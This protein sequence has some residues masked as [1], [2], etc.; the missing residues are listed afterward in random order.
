MGRA[1]IITPENSFDNISDDVETINQKKG[2]IDNRALC[3]LVAFLYSVFEL[4]KLD[5]T[6]AI[7]QS[8]VN[9]KQSRYEPI[10]GKFTFE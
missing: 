5:V 6:K 2:L 3:V 4:I 8:D 9:L 1:A 7:F 10:F